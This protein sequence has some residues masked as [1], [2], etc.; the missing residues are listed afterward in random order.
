MLAVDGLECAYGRRPVLRGV[1][2][3]V[4]PG[5]LV[6]VLGPNGAGKSTLIKAIAHLMRPSAGRVRIDGHDVGAMGR[7]QRARRL[8]YVP[9]RSF[10]V[11]VRVRDAVLLGRTP[12]FQLGPSRRD[13]E[14]AE[15]ILVELG[16]GPLA[17]RR[18]HQLSG[19]ELQLVVVARALAQ[20]PRVLLLDEPINHLDVK[21]RL[22]VLA[23]VRSMTR[24]LAMRS[25]IVIHDLNT[26]LQFA[27]GFLLLRD[28][29]VVASGGP[30][31]VSPQSLEQTFSVPASIHDVAG[32]RCVIV[33]PPAAGEEKA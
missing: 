6:A 18:T 28:G 22:D 16:L 33:R 27:D 13:V 31:A 29:R 25:L 15:H 17:E 19:G 23:V 2:C 1:D 7:R 24:R 11:P 20:Q 12:Y 30:E 10:P 9:Q 21:N 14:I 3:R 8:A 5:E 26:A 32:E 4:A